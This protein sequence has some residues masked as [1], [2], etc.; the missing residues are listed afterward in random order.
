MYQNLSYHIILIMEFSRSIVLRYYYISYYH[1]IVID[2]ETNIY[3][4]RCLTELT[5]GIHIVNSIVIV[6]VM[7]MVM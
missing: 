7:V 4:Y 5:T 3:I 2:T 1:I 6:M